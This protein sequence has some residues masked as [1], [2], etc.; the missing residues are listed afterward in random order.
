MI[1]YVTYEFVF[2][3]FKVRVIEREPWLVVELVRFDD[4]QLCGM[5]GIITYICK[6]KGEF[7]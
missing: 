7:G 3:V 4:A 1:G 2:I 5:I 6:E